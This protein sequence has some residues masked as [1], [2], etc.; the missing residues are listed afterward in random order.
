MGTLAQA[1]VQN[2]EGSRRGSHHARV[3][4]RGYPTAESGA[5][6]REGAEYGRKGGRMKMHGEKRGKKA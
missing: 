2:R 6:L 5:T 3:R 1:H 4:R